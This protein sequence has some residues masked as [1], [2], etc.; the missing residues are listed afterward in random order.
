MCAF[1]CD[2][3]FVAAI[4]IKFN[5]RKTSFVGFVRFLLELLF[6]AFKPTSIMNIGCCYHLRLDAL[7]RCLLH[8][9]PIDAAVLFQRH[10]RKEDKFDS[11]DNKQRESL[12]SWVA[13]YNNSE[14][15]TSYLISGAE[16]NSIVKL[17]QTLF[18]ETYCSYY[19]FE[20][21]DIKKFTWF[22]ITRK[23]LTLH[24]CRVQICLKLIKE[25]F[26]QTWTLLIDF[27]RVYK[28]DSWKFSV[29][30]VKF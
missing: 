23:M 7:L 28:R 22:K 24:N 13:T 14:L 2:C 17:D 10:V 5:T 4:S 15:T 3:L 21:S 16:R 20:I 30:R 8:L 26:Y 1:L 9:T 12:L 6:P 18:E 19:T 27:S 29:R 25:V 11:Q